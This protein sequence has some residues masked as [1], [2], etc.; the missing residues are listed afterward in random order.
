M[1]FETFNVFFGTIILQKPNVESGELL[2]AL[3]FVYVLLF[4]SG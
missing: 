1:Y 4:L 2:I 3:P